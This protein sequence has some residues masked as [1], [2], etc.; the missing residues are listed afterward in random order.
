MQD[1]ARPRVGATAMRRPRVRSQRV[2]EAQRGVHDATVVVKLGGRVAAGAVRGGARG[3]RRRGGRPRCRPRS[4]PR[5]SAAASHPRSSPALRVTTPD[6]LDVVPGV[7]PPSTRRSARRSAPLPRA[8]R[9]RDW[10][11]GAQS[12]GLARRSGARAL[13]AV[14]EAL[15]KDASRVVAPLASGP[16]NVNADEAAAALAVGLGAERILFASDV[17]GVLL[18][19]EVADEFSRPTRRRRASRAA[20][21]RAGSCPS[22]WPRSVRPG[23]VRVR[24]SVR[25]R[26]LLVAIGMTTCGENVMAAARVAVLRT[27]AGGRHDRARRG[28]R[29]SGTTRGARTSISAAGS[30]SSASVTVTVTAAAHAQL[31]ELWHASNLYWTEPTLR[32]ATLL[33][34]RVGGAQ[35]FSANSGA[36]AN[37]GPAL[38]S[39]AR[40][41]AARGSSRSRRVPRPDARSTVRRRGS[42]AMGGF[43]RSSPA[44][45]SPGRT[46]W[47]RS[48]PPVS[49][50]ASGDHHPRAGARRGR[51]R[52]ARQGVRSCRVGS[53]TRARRAALRRRGAVGVGRTGPAT[54]SRSSLTSS[55]SRKVSATHRRAAR[56]ATASP[57]RSARVT[58]ARPSSA[59]W[60]RGL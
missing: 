48:R 32:L 25:P 40:R 6:V 31:D 52:P 33:S 28:M 18:D 49:P 58:T 29:G 4:R 55:C 26:F 54:K 42:P 30:P 10:P 17:P 7:S 1:R 39:R 47:S 35:A 60:C 45:P 8:Q 46:T 9:R 37:E 56:C 50:G 16:L 51:R 20:G 14:V 3:S 41:P 13:E 19:G 36:E 44:S 11:P 24:R 22:S 12:L 5:W 23:A 57:T 43:G 15:A 38:R 21:S 59:P 53:R 27:Y 2:R 34:E